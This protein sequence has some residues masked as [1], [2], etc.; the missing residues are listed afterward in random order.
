MIDPVRWLLPRVT[1]AA[2]TQVQCI[3]KYISAVI[4]SCYNHYL[5]DSSYEALERSL[6]MEGQ[7]EY[8]FNL[9]NGGCSAHL[10][11]VL[12]IMFPPAYIQLNHMPPN[13]VCSL[14]NTR[15]WPQNPLTDQHRYEASMEPISRAALI[16]LRQRLD[17][18]LVKHQAKAV[19]LCPIRR[20]IYDQLFGRLLFDV[21]VVFEV[22]S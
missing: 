14:L 6:R 5:L 20:S 3:V 13:S 1:P 12:S 2:A 15:C 16:G 22:F 8:Q 9:A 11:Q 19:G 4:Y 10:R 17:S 7:K 21:R 18:S